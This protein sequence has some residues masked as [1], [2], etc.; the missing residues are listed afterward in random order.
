VTSYVTSPRDALESIKK[1]ENALMSAHH[2]DKKKKT[3]HKDGAIEKDE[4]RIFLISL[5]QR[6][7]YFEG[8][9]EIDIHGDGSIDKEEFM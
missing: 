8:F 5:R 7:E 6:L 3:G 1:H 9:S 4:F 2:V